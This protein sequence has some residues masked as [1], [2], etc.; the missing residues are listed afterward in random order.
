MSVVYVDTSALVAFDEPGA[1]SLAQR[2]NESAH[3]LASSILEAELRATFAREQMSFPASLV[4]DIEWVLPDRPLTS[5]LTTAPEA[6]SL[7]GADLW[8]LATAPCVPQ[9]SRD[10]MFVTLDARQ[11]AVVE[12]LSSDPDL[13]MW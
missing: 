11:R 6:V 5:E 1:A 13:G 10:I 7:R 9:E 3:L 4:S 2:L 8:H 12:G